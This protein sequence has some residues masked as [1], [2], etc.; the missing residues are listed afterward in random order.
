MAVREDLQ[1]A[2]IEVLAQGIDGTAH[3]LTRRF[4]DNPRSVILG[5]SSFWEGVDLPGDSLKVLMVARL[6]FNVPTDPV[7]EART[8]LFEEPFTEYALPQA[9]LKFRQGFGRLIR[10]KTDRGVVVV[11]DK[12]IISVSYTHLTLT[13][14]LLV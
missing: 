2:G 8:E 6:P 11:L 13:T 12:R 4:L 10:T 14:I 9:I 7:F 3:Q 5:T 1:S